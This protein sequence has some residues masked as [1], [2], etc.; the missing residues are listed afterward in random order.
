MSS[1]NAIPVK[2]FLCLLLLLSMSTFA[3]VARPLS[4]AQKATIK[5]LSNAYKI[6]DHVFRSEQPNHKA[7]KELQSLGI[8]ILLNLRHVRN[9]RWKGRGTKLKLEHIP[10]NTW[11]ISYDEL[12][13][14]T[15]LILNAKEPVLV[16]CW[17][18]SDRTGC[19]IACYRII[20]FHW[21]KEEAINEL[22]KGGFGFHEKAFP[23]I[24]KLLNSIDVEKF[25]T[26]VVKYLTGTLPI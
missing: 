22:V 4:W 24:V 20:K 1:I 10:I 2:H 17:H 15:G 19:I 13:Q 16:H 11:R 9:D 25:K 18:G 3:Q 8:G 5:G 12:V 14:A 21:T 23:N 7:M 26:D 6:D